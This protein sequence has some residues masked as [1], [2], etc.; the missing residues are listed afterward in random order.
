M[1]NI[2]HEILVLHLLPEDFWSHF[3]LFLKLKCETMPELRLESLKMRMTKATEFQRIEAHIENL[4]KLKLLTL[5]KKKLVN[6]LIRIIS[7]HL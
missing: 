1:S 4:K 2:S 3:F 6:P 5:R 7:I